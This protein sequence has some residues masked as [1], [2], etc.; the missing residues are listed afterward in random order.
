MIRELEIQNFKRLR[1]VSLGGDKLGQPLT[2]LEGKNAQGKTSI[3]DALVASLCGDKE[4]PENPIREGETESRIV[5]KTTNDLKIEKKLSYAKA[6]KSRGELVTSLVVW[7]KSGNIVAR[8]QTFLNEMWG[9]A[10]ARPLQ[11]VHS[12]GKERM[13][14]LKEALGVDFSDL[15]AEIGRIEQERLELG[16]QSK[17][18]TG[19]LQAYKD[20]PKK[21]TPTR[22]ADEVMKDIAVID[23][24]FEKE[25]NMEDTQINRRKEIE[26]QKNVISDIDNQ[27]KTIDQRVEEMQEKIQA[28]K[29]HIESSRK[30]QQVIGKKKEREESKLKQMQGG[31][32]PNTYEVPKEK[33]MEYD[34]LKTEL[35]LVH[36][37]AHISEQIRMRDLLNKR[38]KDEKQKYADCTAEIRK[39]TE[40][41]V[42]IL[43][44]TKF[45]IPGMSFGEDD[46]TLGGINF[47]QCSMSEK[48]KMSIG[49]T[50]LINPQMRL[51][52]LE[53]GSSLDD[54]AM[55]EIEKIARKNNYQIFV[56]KVKQ[57]SAPH[58]LVI[59]EGGVKGANQ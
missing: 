41:K 25:R 8:P 11:I 6:G 58:C 16:R 50:A 13:L 34:G 12:T 3:I 56:E 15:D 48:I 54:E 23:Q 24:L 32:D 10:I 39:V 4:L 29:D 17:L 30:S 45:P 43:Q 31:L 52:F 22:T 36:N 28:L 18:T 51:M 26:A 14:T 33:R 19:Q 57:T 7:D 47:S 21:Q 20:A 1:F 2:V 53:D 44:Q 49:I 9:K 5:I 40:K 38:L 46:I 55:G 27:L 35:K 59:E 42:K 37:N